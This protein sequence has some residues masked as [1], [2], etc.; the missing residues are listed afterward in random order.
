VKTYLFYDTETTGLSRCF[1]QVVQFAAIR[2]DA[3]FRE[4]ERQELLIR[5]RPDVV[6]AP[7]AFLTHRIPLQ[8]CQQGV[9]ESEGI[10]TI[11]RLLNEPGTTSLGYNTLGF[12]DE[13]LRFSFYRNLL[14]PYSHQHA[15]GCGRMDLYPMTVAYYLFDKSDL[16]WPQSN[17]TASF[18]LEALSLA[19]HLAEGQAHD[20]M[21]DVE[22]TLELARRLA[23]EQPVWHYLAGYSSRQ[24]S[25]QRISKLPPWPSG[26]PSDHGADRLGLLIDGRFGAAANFIT[27]VLGLGRHHHYRNQTRWL[28]LDQPELTAATVESIADSAWVVTIKPGEPGLLLPWLGRYQ[29]LLTEPRT[30]LC[31]QNLARLAA[32]PGLLQ[33]IRQHNLEFTWPDI[34]GLDLD[35]ALYQAGFFSDQELTLG[36][37][38]RAAPAAEKSAI[39][40]QFPTPNSRLLAQ[41][42]VARNYPEV[43]SSDDLALLDS[44]LQSLGH[45]SGRPLDSQGNPHR[46]PA[47][48]LLEIEQLQ[49]QLDEPEALAI[50]EELHS[51]LQQQFPHGN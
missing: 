10:A 22:A 3:R 32:E 23:K 12:D 6:P 21:T 33:A 30:T 13:L 19:N 14:N 31:Q 24:Q 16:T 45:E 4:L 18:K 36:A 46:A 28:R 51:H 25:A 9:T 17:D 47:A 2:T 38:L 29:H 34:P 27:P 49:Q 8:R 40:A 41:L 20:A 37:E 26:A 7:R 35:A 50:L 42:L 11:H 48:V 15:N 39:A 5:L 43:A 44:R 1:D